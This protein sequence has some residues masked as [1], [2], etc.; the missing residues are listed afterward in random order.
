MAET[1]RD[2]LTRGQPGRSVDGSVSFPPEWEV[3]YRDPA[4][5][6]AIGDVL[7]T[8]EA[9][10]LCVCLAAGVSGDSIPMAFG[11]VW[12]VPKVDAAVIVRGEVVVWDDSVDKVDD[13]AM[14]PATGDFKC[15]V[16]MESKGATTDETIKVD[17]NRAAVAVT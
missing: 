1:G 10:R 13:D 3:H 6:V 17:I 8:M 9:D 7:D 15:G 2:W 4:A 16:A 11:G 5:T 12:S 14:S